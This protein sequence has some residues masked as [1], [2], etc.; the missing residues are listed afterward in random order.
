MEA[1]RVVYETWRE[2]DAGGLHAHTA[3]MFRDGMAS[4]WGD[5]THRDHIVR[6]RTD[7][8]EN[9]TTAAW[10]HQEDFFGAWSPEDAKV[11]TIGNQA[12]SAAPGPQ[13]G[14]IL[15]AADEQP[16]LVM[17]I[18]A[19]DD[20]HGK[21]IARNLY[22]SFPGPQSGS[23]FTPRLSLWLQHV[24]D[25]GY[26]A[27]EFNVRI[28]DTTALHYS[29]DGQHWTPASQIDCPPPSERG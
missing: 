13:F 17:S 26:L 28:S 19:P 27:R 23:T 29:P 2:S 21:A 22:G 10:T 6:H 3:G 24:R 18:A 4:F 25:R 16:E 14:E 20:P 5:V 8:L 11:W 7:D 1:N 9:Y 12:V 15:V